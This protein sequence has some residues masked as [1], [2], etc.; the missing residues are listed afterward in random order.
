M[1]RTKKVSSTGRFGP[2]YGAKLRRRVLE[3]EQKRRAPY[4]CPS[5]ATTAL[6]RAA[7][8]I[9]TCRKCGL[10]F[11]GGAYIP[12]TDAG[13]AAKRAVEQ[14]IAGDLITL[15]REEESEETES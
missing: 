6:K 1:G 13:R 14:R 5:C 7:A 2:R 10:L 11:A 9:W 8:G 15:R 4:R 3:I 12:F